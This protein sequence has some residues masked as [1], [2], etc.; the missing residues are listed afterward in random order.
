M[1]PIWEKAR[2]K[3]ERAEEEKLGP[4]AVEQEALSS[5]RGPS[6]TSRLTTSEAI[7]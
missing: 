5:R 1:R 4:G 2:K 7:S 6:K 3:L